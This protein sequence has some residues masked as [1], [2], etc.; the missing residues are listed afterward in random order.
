MFWKF[1]TTDCHGIYG[2][3]YE[4]AMK[5][6]SHELKSFKKIIS[7]NIPN[8]HVPLMATITWLGCR[9][10]VQT[11]VPLTK[12]SIIY[13]SADAGFYFYFYFYFSFFIFYFHF[14]FFIFYFSFFIFYFLFFIFFPSFQKE[15]P[16]T[17]MS[18]QI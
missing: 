15:K 17:T 1:S 8:L 3:D 16:F 4:S 13:G 9:L 5:T 12:N 10:T 18:K 11:I 6:A 7:C 2:N 14:S